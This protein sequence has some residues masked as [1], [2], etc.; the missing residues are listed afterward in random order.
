ME[1]LARVAVDGA[2]DPAV[3]DIDEDARTARLNLKSLWM[4]IELDV[5]E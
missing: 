2:H 1:R 5:E 3:G 4:R